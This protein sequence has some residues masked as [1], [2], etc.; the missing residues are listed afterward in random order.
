ML[1]PPLQL[2]QKRP[3]FKK[4]TDH[5]YHQRIEITEENFTARVVFPIPVKISNKLPTTSTNILRKQKV[6]KAREK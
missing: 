4:I 3:N 6:L 2:T 1:M 5:Q